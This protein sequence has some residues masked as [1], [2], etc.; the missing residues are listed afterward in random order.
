MEAKLGN[1]RVP[2]KHKPS[3]HEG[4]SWSICVL[5]TLALIVWLLLKHEGMKVRVVCRSTDGVRVAKKKKIEESPTNLFK[6]K[7]EARGP[8]RKESRIRTANLAFESTGLWATVVGRTFLC[9]VCTSRSKYVLFCFPGFFGDN[10]LQSTKQINEKT[11]TTKIL[12]IWHSKA[13]ACGQTLSV[14]HFFVGL[15]IRS[16][17]VLFCFSAYKTN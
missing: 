1:W 4:F 6:N 5:G 10:T 8:K 15:H 3:C 9:R 13:R 2:T 17:Y 11:K 12:Q 14:E 7:R 16:K